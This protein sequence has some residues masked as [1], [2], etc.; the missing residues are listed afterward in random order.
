MNFQMH[1]KT[2]LVALILF[3]NSLS[4]QKVKIDDEIAYIDTAA[5]VK[6][7]TCGAFDN[8]CSICNLQGKEII[9][10][11][12]LKVPDDPRFIYFKISFLG[13]NKFIELRE[14][15]KKIIK[16]LY[17]NNAISESGELNKERIDI[18]VEKYGN[19]VTGNI[20]H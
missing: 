6:L 18:L 13:L 11:S 4:A 15:I 20:R 9:Y 2:L 7:K 19:T 10:I 5:Y 16:I 12:K 14:P 8:F 3:A 17:E 1:F